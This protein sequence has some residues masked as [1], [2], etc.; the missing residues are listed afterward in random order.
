VSYDPKRPR[1]SVE[2]GPELDALLGSGQDT[3]ESPPVSPNDADHRAESE[4]R[5]VP[6]PAAPMEI[7]YRLIAMGVLGTLIA[8]W[9]A[10][11]WYR[12]R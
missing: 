12:R 1:P 11:R 8:M 2:D 7:D 10:I 4:R 3:T 9:L 6:T 5:S